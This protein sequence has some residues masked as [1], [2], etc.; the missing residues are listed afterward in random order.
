MNNDYY[1]IA[2]NDA[3]YLMITLGSKHYNNIAV[4]CQ[5]IVEKLL[6]SVAVNAVTDSKLMNSH[7]LRALYRALLDAGINLGLS[8]A[9]LIVLKDYYFEARYPGDTFI[10]VTRDECVQCI[11]TVNATLRAVNVYRSGLG[12]T[13][14][15]LELKLNDEGLDL[16]AIAMEQGLRA[17]QIDSWIDTLP[18]SIKY[19]SRDEIAATVSAFKI[20]RD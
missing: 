13:T 4:N 2:I 8:M 3:E 14:K 12:L 5:Q 19:L 7:N 18:P 1:D 10:D 16:R 17:D 11:D 20:F 6:K 15:N 9:E